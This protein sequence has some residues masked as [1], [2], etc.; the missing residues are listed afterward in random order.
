VAPGE[1]SVVTSAPVVD[2]VPPATLTDGEQ[3]DQIKQQSPSQ[4]TSR[5]EASEDLFSDFDF[6]DHPSPFEEGEEKKNSDDHE[7]SVTGATQTTTTT[8]SQVVQDSQANPQGMDVGNDG[9]NNQ[10][11]QQQLP[12]SPADVASELQQPG[13]T[14]L[15]DEQ[16]QQQQPVTELNPYPRSQDYNPVEP[17]DPQDF[18]VVMPGQFNP[19]SQHHHMDP[20]IGNPDWHNHQQQQPEGVTEEPPFTH[21]EPV[22][23]A[24]AEIPVDEV[25]QPPPSYDE[26]QTMAP[27]A[28]HEASAPHPDTNSEPPA[29]NDSTVEEMTKHYLESLKDFVPEW[30]HK[31]LHWNS[32]DGVSPQFVVVV[33]SIVIGFVV[34]HVVHMMMNKMSN[35]KPLL[36]K[37][38]HLDKQLFKA[39]NEA[40]IIKR[41]MDQLRS[42]KSLLL[43]EQATVLDASAS[44]N[45]NAPPPPSNN[46]NHV[47]LIKELDSV[48]AQMEAWKAESETSKA[49]LAVEKA[50]VQEVSVARDALT[51]ELTSEREKVASTKAELQE[52][53]SVLRELIEEK[54]KGQAGAT[55]EMQKAYET[56]RE[57][58]QQFNV[59]RESVQKYEHKVKKRE[60]EVKEKIQENRRLRA[61]AAN[62]KLQVERVSKERDVLQK[63]VENF[64]QVDEDKSRQL[65]ELKTKV[66]SLESTQRDLVET[67]DQLDTRD[68]EIEAKTSEI[69]ALKETIQTLE[70]IIK[71]SSAPP[72]SPPKVAIRPIKKAPAND[73]GEEEDGGWDLEDDLDIGGDDEE[74]E[75]AE[76]DANAA[77][78]A[79]PAGAVDMDLIQETSRLKVD[80][81]KAQSA[82]ENLCVQLTKSESEASEAK[83]KLKEVAVEMEV[84]REAKEQAFQDKLE[85][86][87][88][89]E[90]LT[91]YFN[92][93]NS[94][95]QKQ[96]GLQ[97]ARLDDAE[98]GSESTAKKLS[99]LYDE[100][101]AAKSEN[102]TLKLELEDQERSLKSQIV[103]M[104]KKQHESWL[105]V[106]Q[107]SRK[108]ADAKN[109]MQTL[110]N[111]LTLAETKLVEQDEQN[112]SLLETIEKLQRSSVIS[113][114][115]DNGIYTNGN[116]LDHGVGHASGPGSIGDSS[117]APESMSPP[118][119]LPELP[120]LPLM[121]TPATASGAVDPISAAAAAAGC[122]PPHAAPQPLGYGPPPFTMYPSDMRPAPL[123]KQA[124][125]RSVHNSR[126]AA[127]GGGGGRSPSPSDNDSR[128]AMSDTDGG[129]AR[130]GGNGRYEAGERRIR[131]GYVDAYAGG[132]YE[133]P[134]GGGRRS[135]RRDELD[136]SSTRSDFSDYEQP[137]ATGAGSSS[138]RNHRHH[139]HRESYVMSDTGGGDNDYRANNSS[140]SSRRRANNTRSSVKRK[141]GSKTTPPMVDS[142]S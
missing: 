6:E 99:T 126:S 35:E 117:S 134:G 5:E 100:L 27:F 70:V 123:G 25:T 51:L 57:Q 28:G 53:E 14:G 58:Q 97:M 10:I 24:I 41:E 85:L 71:A 105:T 111:R 110:R 120:P 60:T 49:E 121:P 26:P 140:S 46:N 112:K 98:Q 131:R 21:D 42:E 63:S 47:Q 17:V 30:L 133:S 137:S 116:S 69:E 83:E 1:P 93:R 86:E 127:G 84:S 39:R 108:M 32:V 16:Q 73:D 95:L 124:S 55:Q 119:D 75:E 9:A 52:A 82:C 56:L 101:E 115:P 96:L 34:L 45:S 29:S 103:T 128:Y 4:E 136:Y 74:D 114:K 106:R 94:E 50:A 141:D 132:G 76:E 107:E 38:A 43:K 7:Q 89:H 91:Q 81:K 68:S 22:D 15:S 18:G 23:P 11:P 13:Q 77:P 37:I 109:E 33:G 54:K 8:S 80:L 3:S 66:E 61:D 135:Q 102:K 62:A 19:D 90:V 79:A 122:Y 139:P 67:R 44:S 125:R 88:K 36:A 20:N 130:G 59:L 12:P 72:P 40:L 87:R 48:K 138:R 92:Q 142:Y 2:E 129:G 104:E 113:T 118:P 65:E 64:E 31:S 78:V